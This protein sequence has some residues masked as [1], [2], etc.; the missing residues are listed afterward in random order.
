MK[1]DKVGQIQM[2]T[3]AP[4]YEE[5]EK[6]MDEAIQWPSKSSVLVAVFALV[7][8][9]F[10]SIQAIWLR[11]TPWYEAQWASIL[12]LFFV[13]MGMNYWYDRQRRAAM[14]R[15]KAMVEHNIDEYSQMS[16][17]LPDR[18]ERELTEVLGQHGI[19]VER[20]PEPQETLN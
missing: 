4:A 3:T 9:F 12:F 8:A 15:L 7:T 11:G 14:L 19:H 10:M 6:Q 18:I 13:S 5:W 17:E 16:E 2:I 1:M 20:A